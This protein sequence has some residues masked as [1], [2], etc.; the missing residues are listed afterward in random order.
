VSIRFV[1]VPVLGG[2]FAVIMGWVY[3]RRPLLPQPLAAWRDSA[4]D[5]IGPSPE[6]VG[7]LQRTQQMRVTSEAE[8]LARAEDEVP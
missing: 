3:R 4:R 7:I 2:L 8:A 5:P 1:A 6:I